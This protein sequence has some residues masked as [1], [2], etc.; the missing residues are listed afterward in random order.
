MA[1][2]KE[3]LALRVFENKKYPL[4]SFVSCDT[5]MS[6]LLNSKNFLSV[7]PKDYVWE[8]REW[9]YPLFKNKK[10]GDVFCI[11]IIVSEEFSQ[12]KILNDNQYLRNAKKAFIKSDKH[13]KKQWAKLGKKWD[14]IAFKKEKKGIV[15]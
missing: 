2:K 13:S 3:V 10:K 9:A 7:H 4:G 1:I 12:F 14:K 15:L 8:T 6:P 11:E 5:L